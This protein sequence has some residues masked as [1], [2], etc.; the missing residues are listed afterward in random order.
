MKQKEQKNWLV[1]QELVKYKYLTR[2]HTK[3]PEG[4]FC[5]TINIMTLYTKRG[6]DGTTGLFG[7]SGRISKTSNIT[8]ALGTLDELNAVIGVCRAKYDKKGIEIL[9]RKA[10]DILF[11]VQ[12]HL[13]TIQAELAGADKHITQ[14]KVDSLGDMTDAIE[15]TLEPITS[16]LLPGASELSA[17]VDLARTVSR[18]AERA[19]I[20]AADETTIAIHSETLAYCN[21]LSSLMYAMV[22]TTNDQLEANESAPT[23]E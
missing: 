10:S 1:C 21:R 6:D 18:R 8:E 20:R 9:G 22:R 19:V 13:F 12:Q 14:D 15:E 7:S 2:K 17:F 3:A 23:Y 4:V 16:F 11:D 5:Y